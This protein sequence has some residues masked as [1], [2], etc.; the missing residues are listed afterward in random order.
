VTDNV[1]GIGA[2]CRCVRFAKEITGVEDLGVL[3]QGGSEEIGTYVEN[4]MTSELSGNVI[5]NVDR[6]CDLWAH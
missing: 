3:G 2:D 1:Y 6:Q 4:L 5:D